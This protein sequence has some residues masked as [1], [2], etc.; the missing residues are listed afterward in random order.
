[1]P[2]FVLVRAFRCF[3]ALSLAR[4]Y[5][6]EQKLVFLTRSLS[7]SLSP[8][9]PLCV[10]VFVCV[11]PSLSPYLSPCLYCPP[12][13]SFPLPSYNSRSVAVDAWGGR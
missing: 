6:S 11:F 7:L 4:T 8:S 5:C 10:F 1:M 3:L 2:T 12:P 13:P 9:L